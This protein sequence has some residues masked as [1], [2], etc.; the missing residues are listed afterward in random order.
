MSDFNKNMVIIKRLQKYGFD[1]EIDD[2]G[3]GYSSL[4]MLKD[5]SADVLKIDM[6]FLRAS[7]NE[8]IG[9]A[10]K[11][12]MRVITEGVEKKTQVDMLYDMGCKMF[13]GYYFSKPIPVDE[14]EKKYNIG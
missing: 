8:I 1:I 14:F 5:I 10:N 3:S 9:L 2:F 4:I 12:G 6:G 7:E 13:Q 11:L